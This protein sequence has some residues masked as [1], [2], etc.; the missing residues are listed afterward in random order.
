MMSNGEP[1][2]L[3][4]L[5]VV[6]KEKGG[7]DA[8]CKNRLWDLVGEEY[9]LGVKVGSSVELVY[10]KH[11][12]ALET[13]L[14]NVADGEFP[15]CGLVDDR[16][17]FRKRLIEAQ[18][19][20]LSDDYGE[21]EA[22]DELERRVCECPDGRKMC[23]SNRVKGM[24]PESNVAELER[25]YEYLDGRKL[26]GA[27]RIKGK[28]KDSSGDEFDKVCD[29]LDR[30]KLC[31]TNRVKGLNPESNVAKKVQSEGVVDLDMLDRGMDE[32]FH[33]NLC[34]L[35]TAVDILEEFDEGKTLTVD[36]S[37]AESN[38]PRLSDGSKSCDNDDD[39]DSD[40]VLILDPS[41]V[42][43]ES[44]GRKRKRESKSEMLSWVTSIAKNPCDPAVGSIPEKSKWK[45][46]SSQEI[47]KQ[48][49]LFRE[50]V[51]LKKDFETI[52]ERLSWQG[53]RMHPSMYDDRNGAMYNLRQRLKCDKGLVLGKSKSDEVSSASS[54]GTHGGLERTPSPHADNRSEKRL[55]DSC[56]ARSS[57][58]K[59]ARV[60]IPVGPNHQ[61]EVPEWTGMTYESDSK[62]LGTRIWPPKTVNSKKLFFERDPIGKG[63]QD[64]CGCQVLGSVECVRFHIAK[65]RSK[66]KLE[67]GE[68]F[69]QWNLHK[70]GEEVR[71]SWKEQEEKK[72]QDVV[73]SNPASL[74]KCYWDHLFK[75][76]PMK[77][78]EDLV[79]YYFNVF[80][81]QRRAY[82]NRH[83]PD[84]I[85]S[86][87]DESEFTPL[88]KVFGHQTQTSRGFTLLSPK[89]ATDRREKSK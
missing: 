30:R 81:L 16:V 78:R 13:C 44:F 47:W 75:T 20:S 21:E 18:A 84:N 8:V 17:K 80:L 4:K 66:V 23:G 89:K 45:S 79:S 41:G 37:D 67:L 65:K 72:F 39:D 64:S 12:S 35:N 54:G 7:Y 51:Y 19:E 22:G 61:A 6:V 46:Y 26:C 32:P 56:T 2:D 15:E 25:V 86:D 88:R 57:L 33:A 83:T 38:M 68:A 63:R 73:K 36:A 58:D 70:V 50:A 76:F 62:W 69:Y 29:N 14:K 77:S 40:E 34:S 43:K 60:H 5:F 9:G 1:L 52:S 74:D 48:A 53:Q 85:D 27:D 24:K 87:D 82:Q 3:Y 31:G 49:L 71:G 10:S 42:D 59:C 28:N 55:L 11:L